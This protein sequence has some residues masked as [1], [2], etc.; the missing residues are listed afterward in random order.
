MRFA[1]VLSLLIA[2]AAVA[3]AIYNPD[4]VDI[5]LLN[6]QLTAPLAVVIITTL[7]LGVVVGIMASV[8]TAI[9]RGRRVRKLEKRLVEVEG[10]AA[11]PAGHAAPAR[12]ERERT[13]AEGAAETQRLAAETQRMAAEAQ[14]RAA[15]MDDPPQ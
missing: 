7:L 12:T 5:R 9:A 4:A 15:E 14:R 1:L 8:P 2:I 11:A 6:Y 3:F 13:P 10:P